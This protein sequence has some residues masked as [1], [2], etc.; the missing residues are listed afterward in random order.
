M[1]VCS[2]ILSDD[3]T[4][5]VRAYLHE[6][7]QTS[8]GGKPSFPPETRSLLSKFLSHDVYEDCKDLVTPS[9]FT[10]HVSAVCWSVMC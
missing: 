10:F 9:G 4:A 2:D 1:S 5:S 8:A 3:R 7:E 6:Y